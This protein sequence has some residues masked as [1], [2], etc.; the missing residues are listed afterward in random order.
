MNNQS[1]NVTQI[2]PQAALA[3][4]NTVNKVRGIPTNN[5]SALNP[6]REVYYDFQLYRIYD[7][8][9]AKGYYLMHKQAWNGTPPDPTVDLDLTDYFADDI[10]IPIYCGLNVDENNR[11]HIGQ[12][13]KDGKTFVMGKVKGMTGDISPVPL[14]YFY[15]AVRPSV[16]WYNCDSTGDNYYTHDNEDIYHLSFNHTDFLVTVDDDTD[17]TNDERVLVDWLGFTVEKYGDQRICHVKILK[18]DNP[19]P[20]DIPSGQTAPD[21]ENKLDIFFNVTDVPTADLCDPDGCTTQ[22]HQAVISAQTFVP[23]FKVY[24]CVDGAPSDTPVYIDP[25]RLKFGVGIQFDGTDT[26]STL[27]CDGDYTKA[28]MYQCCWKINVCHTDVTV[29]TGNVVPASEG[30]AGA[31]LGDVTVACDPATGTISVTK[32]WVKNETITITVLGP[33]S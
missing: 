12:L 28:E 31:F 24:P 29:A 30:D 18:F 25:A 32:T 27:M 5:V 33:C 21:G 19:T 15:Y 22:K 9:S 10:T 3:I 1:G 6:A 14:V 26:I 2:T 20:P 13:N 7:Y 11:K 8:D 17:E 4:V 16:G 23:K